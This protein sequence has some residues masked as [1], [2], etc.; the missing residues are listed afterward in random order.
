[1]GKTSANNIEIR[2]KNCKVSQRPKTRFNLAQSRKDAKLIGGK[3]QEKEFTPDRVGMKRS[4]GEIIAD[5][6]LLRF[7]LC[8]FASLRET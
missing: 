1:V 3:F 8:V 6:L 7:V 5:F 4:D 2:W